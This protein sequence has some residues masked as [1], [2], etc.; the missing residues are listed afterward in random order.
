MW[1]GGLSILASHLAPTAILASADEAHSLMLDLPPAHHSTSQYENRDSAFRRGSW[2]YYPRCL[3]PLL[4]VARRPRTDQGLTSN[5]TPFPSSCSDVESRGRLLAAASAES[6]AWLDVPPVSYLGL[7]MSDEAIRIA[8]SLKVGAP[9]GQPHTNVHTVAVTLTSFL[10]TQLSCR[11]S[12]GRLSHHNSII[13]HAL[14]AAKF[15]L[16]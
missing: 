10:Q 2:I 9:L 1:S 12:Q 4:Q 8:V 16:G 6:S 3:C 11:F 14:T 15:P 7:R 5:L 13:Q